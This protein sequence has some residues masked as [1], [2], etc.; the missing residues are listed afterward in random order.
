MVHVSGEPRDRIYRA[1]GEKAGETNTEDTRDSTES[2]TRTYMCGWCEMI[3]LGKTAV[4]VVMTLAIELRM[5][6]GEFVTLI[7]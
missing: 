1:H 4:V 3:I 5:M 2:E 6:V 7:F